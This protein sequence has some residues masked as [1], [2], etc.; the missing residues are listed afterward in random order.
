MGG[1]GSG[2]SSDYGFL[3]DKCEDYLSID[4]AWLKRQGSLSPGNSGNITWSRGGKT[5]S[6]IGYRAEVAGLRLIYRTRRAED[7]WQGVNELI[8]FA[9][10]DAN[11]HGRRQWFACPG[12]NRRCRIIYGGPYFRCRKCYQLKYE[13]QY[14]PIFD[15]AANQR[16]KLRKRLG[17]VGSLEG[18][19][20]SKPKGMHWKRYRLL[21]ARDQELEQRWCMDLAGWLERNSPSS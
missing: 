16:H 10:T 4:I 1:R 12:C 20:P 14:E 13:S 11:F 3:V 21:E 6:S 19:F 7:D 17:H 15:R 18:P 9:W 5:T 2:R 8:P